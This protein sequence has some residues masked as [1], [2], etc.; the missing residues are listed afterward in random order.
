MQCMFRTEIN[1]ADQFY[2]YKLLHMFFI[3]AL[4]V[5]VRLILGGTVDLQQ[6][7]C[8]PDLRLE[9]KGKL[10]SVLRY[11]SLCLTFRYKSFYGLV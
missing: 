6:N 10:I 5:N 3:A 9:N 2:C 4:F 1:A 11:A 8:N 7:A